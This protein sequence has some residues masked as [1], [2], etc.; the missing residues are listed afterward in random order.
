MASLW[1]GAWGSSQREPDHAQLD[2]EREP[3]ATSKDSST[4]HT[5]GGA[6][7]EGTSFFDGTAPPAS[8]INNNYSDLS[9]GS[10][11]TVGVIPGLREP[12]P[13]SSPKKGFLRGMMPT[14][15]MRGSR[16]PQ[17]G[18]AGAAVGAVGLS[19]SPKR[20]RSMTSAAST[21]PSNEPGARRAAGLS[22]LWALERRSSAAGYEGL[23]EM[24]KVC[25]RTPQGC[26]S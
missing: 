12:K 15:M 17:Q 16:P 20:G 11:E 7:D 24:P 4:H 1:G 5:L 6:T 25:V 18:D 14:R 10:L 23:P 13:R 8:R 26:V 19:P 3:L 21:N 2:G 9:R 22:P